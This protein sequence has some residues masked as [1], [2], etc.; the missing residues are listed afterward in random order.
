M[1]EMIMVPQLF[2]SLVLDVLRD[3]QKLSGRERS[4]LSVDCKPVIWKDSTR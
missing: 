4:E 1:E 2:E 3:A